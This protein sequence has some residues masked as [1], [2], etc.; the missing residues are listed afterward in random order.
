[1]VAE[2]ITSRA[3]EVQGL[4]ERV[5]ASGGDTQE[6]KPA[7]EALV[8]SVEPLDPEGAVAHLARA[9]EAV[10]AALKARAEAVL[11][12]IQKASEHRFFKVGAGAQ[13]VARWKQATQDLRGHLAR[14]DA[15]KVLAGL[16]PA[17]EQVEAGIAAIVA[18]RLVEID[19]IRDAHGARRATPEEEHALYSQVAAA[20]DRGRAAM[21]DLEAAAMLD[22]A[23]KDASSKFVTD[24]RNSINREMMSFEDRAAVEKLKGLLAAVDKA[25]SNPAMAVTRT[26]EMLDGASALLTARAQALLK[27]ADR[28]L[29]VARAIDLDASALQ[30]FADR[31][32]AALEE[33]KVTEAIEFADNVLKESARLQ[34]AH[35][36]D[37][38]K[39]VMAEYESAPEGK[40]K[41]EAKRLLAESAAGLRTRDFEAAYDFARKALEGLVGE[42]REAGEAAINSLLEGVAALEGAGV[43]CSQFRDGI[44]EVRTA[45]DKTDAIRGRKRLQEVGALVKQRRAEY[46]RAAEL[47]KRLETRVDRA[48]AAKI[49]TGDLSAR[50]QEAQRRLK[51]ADFAGVTKEVQTAEAKSAD[52]FGAK[53]KALITSAQAK[54]K[55]NRN[56]EIDIRSAEELLATAQK[57]LLGKDAEGALDAATR[58]IAEAD[59]AKEVARQVRALGE[60]GTELLEKAAESGVSLSHE[61]EQQIFEAAKGRL[62]PGTKVQQLEALIQVVR[63]QI[64]IGGP[65][66]EL[67][68]AV[69]E[70][71]VVNRT[72]NAVLDIS[73][74]GD[75]A[76][77]D[78]AVQFSGDASVR[79][80]G[81]PPSV[82]EPGD[83]TDL[84]L[85]VSSRRMG[86]IA[87]RVLLSYTDSLTGE[88]KRRTDRRWITF[89][90]PTDTGGAEQFQ[91]REE[92]CIICV[93]AIPP[94]ERMK[95]CECHSTVHLHCASD[96]AD[97]PKC[98]RPLKDS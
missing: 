46:D 40:A 39:R 63:E 52:L 55:H 61:Q 50:L 69:G 87:V 79:I 33:G 58:A 42:A 7:I 22:Q 89:F 13:E 34:D 15:A 57:L 2:A 85:Q 25:R 72:N 86:D 88:A 82:L 56:L 23:L 30:D 12:S 53:A 74:R 43:D 37:F 17:V 24:A 92:K 70:P 41:G 11:A 19:A 14:N 48:T 90:D 10:D 44:E 32:H 20:A 65:R 27:S 81:A 93:G 66:L 47:V 16:A 62:K 21:E 3:E 98:G 75:A 9:R 76:A 4:A 84:E 68:F 36:K 18:E 73:N 80:I 6:A 31:A 60:Q 91:R 29:E 26:Y 51:D 8:A 95:V 77:S 67:S 45:F 96:I 64:G 38:I 97:C 94:T 59:G 49:D 1:M 54:V 5:E 71:P 28:Q 78:I 83:R 35:V